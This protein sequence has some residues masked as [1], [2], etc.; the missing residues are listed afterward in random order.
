MPEQLTKHPDVTLQVL[1]S[2][3]AQCGTQAPQEILKTCPAERFCK[4]PGGEICVYGVADAPQMTQFTAA[5][6]QALAMATRAMP[7][8]PASAAAAAPARPAPAPPPPPPAPPRPGALGCT[9]G[10]RR[11]PRR[12]FAWARGAAGQRSRTG[13]HRRGDRLVP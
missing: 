12:R 7:A 8:T 11:R 10:P 6:W 3:G 13:H 1:R 5:D 2:A 9:G 4:L